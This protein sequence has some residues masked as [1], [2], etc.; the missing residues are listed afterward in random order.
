MISRPNPIYY[1]R[2]VLDFNPHIEILEISCKK[3]AGI[4]AWIASLECQ[5]TIT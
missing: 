5:C 4:A 1:R 3:A 2:R